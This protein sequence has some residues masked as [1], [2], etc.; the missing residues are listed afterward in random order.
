MK[1]TTLRQNVKNTDRHW[2][3]VD[4]DGKNLGR[5]AVL[6]TDTIRGKNR[7]DF[8]PHA[9]GGDY[10]IVLNS[11]KIKVEGNKEDDKLYHRHS[12]YLG[13]LKT[14][15]L[16]ELRTK[17]P[18]KIL[19][20]AVSGMLPKNRLRDKQLKRLFLIVG[21]KN[22]HEAQKCEPLNFNKNEQ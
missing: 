13:E 18:V 15:T 14:R 8:T 6:I 21:D 7:P 2:W 22:P 10:V 20:L 17:N 11:E 5:L 16:S 1:K 3:I 9:D 19:Q 4:A 12:R